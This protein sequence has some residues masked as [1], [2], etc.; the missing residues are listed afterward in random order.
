VNA[1]ETWFVCILT[2]L[3]RQDY[4]RKKAKSYPDILEQLLEICH[5]DKN[6]LV[7]LAINSKAGLF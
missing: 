3:P 2:G 1:D 4:A 7:S 5:K 6:L